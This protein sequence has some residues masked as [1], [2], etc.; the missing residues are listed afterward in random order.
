MASR[1]DWLLQQLGITQ[2]TLRRPVVLQGE[3]AVTLPAGVRFLIV[4]QDLPSLDDALV[5]DVLRALMLRAEQVYCLTPDRAAMLPAETSCS[6]W[7]LGIA[8]PLPFAGVQL[9]TPALSALSNDAG[10]KRALWRQIC[11]DE[12]HFY[13]DGGRSGHRSAD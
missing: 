4:A 2:W 5:C 7:R 8:E 1:R 6:S 13:S 3:I 10:A 9:S 12:Q 11:D